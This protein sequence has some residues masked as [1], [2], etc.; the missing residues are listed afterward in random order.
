MHKKARLFL[1]G[2][3]VAGLASIGQ[4]S[5]QIPTDLAAELDRLLAQVADAPADRNP[6]ERAR[7][8]EQLG[9]VEVRVNMLSAARSA[10]EEATALRTANT[11]DDRDLG[12]LAFKQANVAHIDKR[13]AD[14]DRLIEVAV[15][16]LRSGAPLSPEYADAFR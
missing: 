14:F 3:L 5:A 10:F 7:R 11:P 2:S 16:R 9:D 15:T 6:V 1:A 13:T 12:R 8:L 4:V